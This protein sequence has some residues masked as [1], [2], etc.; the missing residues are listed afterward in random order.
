MKLNKYEQKLTRIIIIG[1]VY[2][3]SLNLKKKL[4]TGN[5]ITKVKE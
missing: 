3:T 5:R 1:C 4:S 2:L